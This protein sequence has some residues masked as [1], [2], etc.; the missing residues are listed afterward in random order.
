MATYQLEL[1][2]KELEDLKRL[3]ASETWTEGDDDTI[4]DDYAGG[5][6]DDA[7]EGGERAGEIYAAR[8]LLSKIGVSWE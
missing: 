6:V 4:I 5:N 1:T 7:Y 3:A 2:D 8:E